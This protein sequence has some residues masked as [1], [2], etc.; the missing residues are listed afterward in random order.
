MDRAICSSSILLMS[1]SAAI[2]RQ[3]A[4]SHTAGS[5]GPPSAIPYGIETPGAGPWRETRAGL[6][7]TTHII[8][9]PSIGA[10]L[11]PG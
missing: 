5:T 1:D 8:A 3:S 11:H 7:W 2:N 6:P 4:P 9:Q 10:P